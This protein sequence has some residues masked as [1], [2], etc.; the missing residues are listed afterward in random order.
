MIYPVDPDILY[1]IEPLSII[2]I[3]QSEL[4]RLNLIIFIS[5]YIACTIC[6]ARLTH[7]IEIYAFFTGNGWQPFAGDKSQLS[8]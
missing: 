1:T 4:S 7:F 3:N 8:T 2:K 6:I 5:F